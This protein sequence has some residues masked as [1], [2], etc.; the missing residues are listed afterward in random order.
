MAVVNVVVIH[1]IGDLRTTGQSYSQPLQDKIRQYLGMADPDA[2]AFHEVNW[3]DIGDAEENDLIRNKY[4]LPDAIFPGAGSIWPPNHALGEVLD[5]VLNASEQARRFLLT[6]VGDV[7]IYLSTKGGNAIRQRMID[8][9]LTL[10]DTLRAQD[11]TRSTHYVS[12]VAHSLGSVV[13]YDT[14]ALFA[15]ELRDRVQGLG[16]SHFFTMGSPLALFTLL[17]Y[18]GEATHYANRGVYLDRPDRSGEWLN[19]YD[20]QDPIAF[21]LK[22]VYPPLPGVAC[23]EYTIQDI[24]VQTGTF[25]AH[26]NYFK[27]DRIASEIAKRLR[28]DYQKDRTG[29]T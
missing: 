4:V 12:I 24:R 26:T 22:H 20:Q 15:N 7:L 6:G 11:P 16:L 10:R 18:G 2:L 14:C 17:Q 19:F 28:L 27:N 1:G 3:S 13:A 29:R 23:R 5:S 21:P 25:H 9:I 8:V